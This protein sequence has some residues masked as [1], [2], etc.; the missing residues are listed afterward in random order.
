MKITCDIIQDL[1]P[2]YVARMLSDDS[3]HLVDEH[4][5]TCEVCR[6]A[7]EKL[8]TE[9]RTLE[10]IKGEGVRGGDAGGEALCDEN[11]QC[12]IKIH[13]FTGSEDTISV[14]NRITICKAEISDG[15]L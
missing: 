2:L 3:C 12:Q 8:K 9:E 13:H 10:K 15:I 5:E 1:L 6:S 4:L 7:L 14:R 11:N